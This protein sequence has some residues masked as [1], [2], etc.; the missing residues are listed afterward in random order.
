MRSWTTH[1]LREIFS[2]DEIDR[3]AF[4]IQRSKAA[5][6]AMRSAVSKGTVK[7]PDG[8]V[9]SVTKTR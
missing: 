5:I 2:G 1:E 3:I 7:V 6:Y 9:N 4:R 8:I